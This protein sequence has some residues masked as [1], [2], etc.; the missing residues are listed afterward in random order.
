M[1]L[2][3]LFLCKNRVRKNYSWVIHVVAA[4]VV[5]PFVTLATYSH[6]F[7]DDYGTAL[8]IKR[9]GFTYYYTS[10]YQ[11]WTGR[12]AFLL[13]NMM[14]PLR[15]GGLR[16]Y[17][18]TAGVL[19]MGLV[20]SCYGLSW[21]LT[22]GL[23]LRQANRLALGSGLVVAM[24]ALLPS[25]A[26]GFYWVVGGYN[27]LLPIMVGFG[28]LAAGCGYA[29]TLGRPHWQWL[30]LAGIFG[31]AALFPGFSEFSACLS[32]LVAGSSL[33]AFPRA[34]WLYRGAAVVS[35]VGAVV[36]LAAPGNLGRLQQH[37]HEW[38]LFRAAGLALG[39]TGYTLLNWLGFPTFWVL[40][41]LGL[42]LWEQL[43]A[44]TGPVAQLARRPL[45]WPF[46]MIGGLLGCYFFSYLTLQQPLPL[47]ARNL[48]YAYFLVTGI[49]GL[50]GAVQLAQ[51]RGKSLP[52]LP[53]AILSILLII[54]LLSD[55][56]GRLR[57]DAIGRGYNT[58]GQ[59]YH[60]WLSG[61]ARR[62]D[63][64]E[65]SRYALLRTTTADSVAV[66]PLPVMPATLFYFDIGP[67]PGLW[68][69]L[70][71]AHYFGKKAVWVQWEKPPRKQQK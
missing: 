53:P 48:L 16:A 38:H 69:N 34:S 10:L 2:S 9:T 13:A 49:F 43:A 66:P 37:P 7:F 18:F 41:G 57:G 39:A 54:S 61:D 40:A 29:A 20:G 5:L 52:R 59:A 56:N 71:L 6:P 67:S 42:P 27:Y 12:Y 46:L 33:I 14:H 64:A 21:S 1:T 35:V 70:H 3:C 8:E 31:S 26:E 60:D 45:L 11:N 65:R 32:L 36:M 47:R 28:G 17:Q 4:A 22:T 55:G 51:R 50:V 19:V 62:F 25:P 30:L 24:L 15:F 63:A 58:V 44:G 68:G 23:P